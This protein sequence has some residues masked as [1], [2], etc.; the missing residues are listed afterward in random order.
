MASGRCNSKTRADTILTT[1]SRART[2]KAGK[3]SILFLNLL[4]IYSP[5][6]VAIGQKT[7]ACAGCAARKT[8]CKFMPEAAVCCRCQEVGIECVPKESRARCTR[9]NSATQAPSDLDVSTQQ[10]S[11][12]RAD[13]LGQREN[14]HCYHPVDLEAVVEDTLSDSASVDVA[15]VQHDLMVFKHAEDLASVLY[16]PDDVDTQPVDGMDSQ[17]EEIFDIG[18]VS[19]SDSEDEDD[20][21]LLA[22]HWQNPRPGLQS[23]S[24]KPSM[25]PIKS[26]KRK[27]VPQPSSMLSSYYD[28][29][30]CS[31]LLFCTM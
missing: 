22:G 14:T 9:G 2:T 24:T 1:D 13:N 8:R 7:R 16:V 10:H 12:S 15:S 20:D 23:K 25:Q 21:T 26:L 5:S 6:I 19:S 17:S 3:P 27:P 11:Q 29:D 31:K 30:T 18:D 4:L 28:R